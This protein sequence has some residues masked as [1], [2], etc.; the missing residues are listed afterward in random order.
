MSVT[1]E[2]SGITTR[3]TIMDLGG[4]LTLNSLLLHPDMQPLCVLKHEQHTTSTFH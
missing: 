2:P 4:N 1:L 3:E